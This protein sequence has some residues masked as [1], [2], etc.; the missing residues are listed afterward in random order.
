MKYP[1]PCEPGETFRNPSIWLNFAIAEVAGTLLLMAIFVGA[2][3]LALFG[4]AL[5]P[6]LWLVTYRVLANPRLEVYDWGVVIVNSIRRVRLSWSDISRVYI[7]QG[8]L[9][10]N[11]TFFIVDRSGHSYRVAALPMNWILQLVWRN[12]TALRA[13]DRME[14][15]GVRVDPQVRRARD[16]SD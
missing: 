1:C 13:L 8:C 2:G 14:Q 15:A 7:D 16:N 3:G 9:P 12:H 5:L 11:G 4:L 6:P 10:G